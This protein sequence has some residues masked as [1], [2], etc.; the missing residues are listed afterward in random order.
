MQNAS[1]VSS[2]IMGLIQKVKLEVL[3]NIKDNAPGE[4]YL[5]AIL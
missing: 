2:N 4:Y 3:Y 1:Y 5:Q